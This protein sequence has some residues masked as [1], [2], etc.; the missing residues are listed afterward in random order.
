[1]REVMTANPK[2]IRA[3]RAGCRGRSS[4]GD[5]PHHALPVVDEDNVLVG[6]LNVHDLFRAGVM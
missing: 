5:H 6:A 3:A 4:H 1:M 2:T